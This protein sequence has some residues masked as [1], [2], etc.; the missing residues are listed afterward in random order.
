LLTLRVVLAANARAAA[1][2]RCATTRCCT[3]R[4]CAPH[5]TQQTTA[6]SFSY[7]GARGFD[8]SSP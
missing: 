1:F 4:P 2:C 7:T 6:L 5:R 3:S 8:Q